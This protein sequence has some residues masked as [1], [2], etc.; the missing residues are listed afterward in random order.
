MR[1]CRDTGPFHLCRRSGWGRTRTSD[2][3][4]LRHVRGTHEVSDVLSLEA[5][6]HLGNR[7]ARLIWRFPSVFGGALNSVVP[8]RLRVSKASSVRTRNE[9]GSMPPRTLYSRTVLSRPRPRDLIGEAVRAP[10]TEAAPPNPS[11]S[12]AS[13][14]VLRAPY[15]IRSTRSPA[16]PA[17]PGARS[18]SGNSGNQ[19]PLAQPSPTFNLKPDYK[20]GI[21]GIPGMW[22]PGNGQAE[23][24]PLPW[25]P[26]SNSRRVTSLA[27]AEMEG[28][29]RN[30]GE[31]GAGEPILCPLFPRCSLPG[32]S[33]R[34][35]VTR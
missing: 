14:S 16:R 1:S 26:I 18:A 4:P 8:R 25:D 15:L 6:I 32:G 29:S 17:R 31:T 11:I 24:Y 23:A 30:L 22:A 13:W 33:L 35:L 2:L 3:C 12:T 7:L 21:P 27:K 20:V 19:R 28:R 9:T 10:C 34:L 5:K